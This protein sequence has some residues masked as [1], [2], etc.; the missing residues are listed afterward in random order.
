[1]SEKTTCPTMW[2]GPCAK[3]ES[4]LFTFPHQ[5]YMTPA[6][7]SRHQCRCGVSRMREAEERARNES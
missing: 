7:R 4:Q 2:A 3:R 1:M 5:C 6:H